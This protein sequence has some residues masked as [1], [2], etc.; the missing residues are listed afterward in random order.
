MDTNRCGGRT[1][2]SKTKLEETDDELL[3]R[4]SICR[5]MMKKEKSCCRLPAFTFL[6]RWKRFLAD[7]S[8]T[9]NEVVKIRR[10]C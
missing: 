8:V 9:T 10:G 2:L 4:L 1:G 3:C 6:F 5:M 7:N